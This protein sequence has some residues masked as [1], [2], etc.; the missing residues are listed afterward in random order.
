MVIAGLVLLLLVSSTD[1]VLFE[2]WNR[3]FGENG[4][5]EVAS[6]VQ[7][8]LDGGYII[9]GSSS[10]D[11]KGGISAWLIK[12]D[13]KGILEWKKPFGIGDNNAYSVVQTSEDGYIFA[14]TE[15][16]KAWLVKT[17]KNGNLDWSKTWPG[18]SVSIASYIEKTKDGGYIIAAGERSGRLGVRWLIKIDKT[19]NEEWIKKFQKERTGYLLYSVQETADGGFILSGIGFT[20]LETDWRAVVTKTDSKG[21]IQV[22]KRI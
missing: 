16:N 18:E 6:S 17:D 19:G 1:A 15:S 8:T 9:S 14:G 20:D 13:S 22:G 21:N 11:K 3:T 5:N 12:T 4:E 2:E 10:F 7:Q